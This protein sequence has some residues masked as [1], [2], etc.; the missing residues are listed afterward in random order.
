MFCFVLFGL[1]GSE[2]E[3][4]GVVLQC[5]LL[6]FR[7]SFWLGRYLLCVFSMAQGSFAESGWEFP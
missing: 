2:I 5:S 1:V 7:F 4:K 3:G 6:C